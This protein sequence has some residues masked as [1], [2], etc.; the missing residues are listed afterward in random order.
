M[1]YWDYKKIILNKTFL[2][3]NSSH[4]WLLTKGKCQMHIIAHVR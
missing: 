1:R 3:L 2:N 4:G